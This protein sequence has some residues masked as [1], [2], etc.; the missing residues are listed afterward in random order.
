MRLERKTEVLS[1]ATSWFDVVDLPQDL[2][3]NVALSCI[4][5][6]NKREF[7]SIYLNLNKIAHY[8]LGEVSIVNT[9]CEVILLE[10]GNGLVSN[11]EANGGW[12]MMNYYIRLK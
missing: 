6:I 8:N 3:L 5:Q 12:G 1:D 11:I 7:G 9:M 2:T 10:Y 4:A